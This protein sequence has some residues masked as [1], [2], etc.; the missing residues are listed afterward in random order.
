MTATARQRLVWPL[1]AVLALACTA[2]GTRFALNQSIT[3]L[4]AVLMTVFGVAVLV[5]LPGL[6]T[7]AALSERS[8][9]A[10]SSFGLLLCG[11]GVAALADFWAWVATPTL[12]RVI[13]AVFLV[14]S[15]GV[16]AASRPT[17]LF[18]DPEL[19]RPPATMLLVALGYL[20]LAYSQ[21]GLGGAHWTTGAPIGDATQMMA[22]RYVLAPDNTLPLLFAQRVAA[23]GPLTVL[24]LPGWH[25]SD[26]PPLQT[27]FMLML[28][29][30]FGHRSFGYQLLGTVLQ[31]LWIP[32]VWILLRSR[33]VTTVRVLVVVICTAATGAIFVNTIYVWPKMLAGAFA[34]AAL[35]V[36]LEGGSVVLVVALAGL[37][38]L[39]H[40][41]VAFSLVALV[42]FLW[43]LRPS[44]VQ[45]SFAVAAG[46]ALYLPWAAYQH[47]LDPPGDRLLKWQLAG[48]IALDRHSFLHDLVTNYLH[49]PLHSFLIN[50]LLN[51]RSLF[52]VP[53]LWTNAVPTWS[54]ILAAVRT[55]SLFSVAFAVGPLLLGA[56]AATAL[57]SARRSMR[58]MGPLLIFVL[59]SLVCWVVLEWG[60]T[61]SASALS[62]YGSYAVLVLVIALAALATTYLPRWAAV[63]IVCANVVWFAILYLPGLGYQ[64]LQ[65]GIAVASDW[66]MIALGLVSLAGLGVALGRSA[67]HGPRGRGLLDRTVTQHAWR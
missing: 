52:V 16:I 51:V 50:K 63:S 48:A 30:L 39:S 3:G 8:L 18:D 6:A 27:G 25:S 57:A 66:P 67:S 9:T 21:G 1:L 24:L 14:V 59:I 64:P 42:P 17:V 7:L 40:G 61:V 2:V 28:Y 23:H 65:P 11:S 32:A 33:A 4:L 55:Q 5:A 15:L 47:F 53:S 54:G 44:K 46:L 45:V 60:G 13:A 12:G 35:A 10:A 58:P 43:K 41:A 26:R 34:L 56:A 49:D 36:V 31:A 29:P 19:W 37:G 62:L 38:F 22:F 20:G